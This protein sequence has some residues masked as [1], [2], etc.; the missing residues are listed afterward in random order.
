MWSPESRVQSIFYTMPIKWRYCIEGACNNG[1]FMDIHSYLYAGLISCLFLFLQVSLL[2]YFSQSQYNSFL[3]W[4]GSLLVSIIDLGWQ[5]VRH[6]IW[7]PTEMASWT[8]PLLQRI[9]KYTKKKKATAFPP[10]W[11]CCVGARRILGGRNRLVYVRTVSSSPLEFQ[12]GAS[13]SKGTAG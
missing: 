13:T 7:Y 10:N 4:F 6:F 11:V 12:N 3:I 9:S 2:I 5:E 8:L 1:Y